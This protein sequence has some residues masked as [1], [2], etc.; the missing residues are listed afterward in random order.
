MYAHFPPFRCPP[1]SQQ[2]ERFKSM[3][4]VVPPYLFGGEGDICQGDIGHDVHRSLALQT[5]L[6]LWRSNPGCLRGPGLPCASLSSVKV[7]GQQPKLGVT[8]GLNWWT[9]LRLSKPMGSHFGGSPPPILVGIGMFTGGTTCLGGK[10]YV[11]QALF[12]G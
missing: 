9:W 8:R 6:S 1:P 4:V 3:L 7:P 10:L 11:R 12:T 2:K 5:G